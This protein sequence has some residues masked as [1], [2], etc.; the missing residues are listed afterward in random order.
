ME[1]EQRSPEWFAVRCGRVTA[2]RISDIIYKTQKGYSTSRANYAAQ[3]VCE[4]LTGSVEQGY[5]NAAMQW[6]T[7]K[8]PE[9]REAYAFERDA[10]VNEIGFAIHPKITLAGASPDGLVDD[11]GMVEIKCPITATHIDTLLNETIADKYIVQMQ[12]QM[13]CTD[14]QWCDFVSYDPRLPL[15]MQLFV[16]RVPRDD[17]RIAALESE[18]TAFLGEVGKTVDRLK[19]RYGSGCDWTPTALDAG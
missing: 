19:A 5:S 2:S 13:A 7:E 11:D 12:W 15:D 18:V 8:E 14:R 4:R 16:K 17:A 9:A 3:L 10:V 1:I 6:G